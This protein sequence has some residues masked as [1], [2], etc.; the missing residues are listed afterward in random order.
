M[1]NI[2]ANFVAIAWNRV[3]DASC[4][5][6]F[7]CPFAWEAFLTRRRQCRSGPWSSTVTDWTD[8]TDWTENTFALSTVVSWHNH[9]VH[10]FEVIDP[11]TKASRPLS[12]DMLSHN[13][14]GAIA[15]LKRG[16]KNLKGC[17]N[18]WNLLRKRTY[19]TSPQDWT[20]MLRPTLNIKAG[21][22]RFRSRFHHRFLST[23]WRTL[24]WT[25]LLVA[26]PA[27]GLGL[28]PPIS[29]RPALSGVVIR[30]VLQV[31]SCDGSGTF[32]RQSPNVTKREGQLH[33]I[34]RMA[35]ET[36]VSM[37]TKINEIH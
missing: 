5:W 29:Q 23:H 21:T 17:W 33:G 2:Q 31:P 11:S 24:H 34:A 22:I 10:V 6:K 32:A 12:F 16:T 13:W 27:L 7:P 1:S 36:G 9:V 15:F 20:M 3:V 26:L 4:N 30:L 25:T 14:N 18:F 35:L 37:F 8:W 28:G 19:A